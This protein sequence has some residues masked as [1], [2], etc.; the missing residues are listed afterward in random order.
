VYSE[1]V[2]DARK[3]KNDDVGILGTEFEFDHTFPTA[4]KNLSLPV[5]IKK[6]RLHSFDLYVMCCSS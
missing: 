6:V 5:H 2:H 1:W 3:V 4:L